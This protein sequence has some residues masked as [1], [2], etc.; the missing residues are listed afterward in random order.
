MKIHSPRA[1]TGM[2]KTSKAVMRNAAAAREDRR[3]RGSDRPSNKVRRG[4]VSRA[5]GISI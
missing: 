4:I 1:L 3:N 2:T 5:D